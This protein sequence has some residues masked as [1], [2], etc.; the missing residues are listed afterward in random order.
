M[1]W[2]VPALALV[3]A[4]ALFALSDRLLSGGFE[5]GHEGGLERTA[6]REESRERVSADLTAPNA[7]QGSE[8]VAAEGTSSDLEVTAVQPD[9]EEELEPGGLRVRVIDAD[10]EPVPG[11]DVELV[12]R[13]P[14]G[15][16]QANWGT[17]TSSAPGGIAHIDLARLTQGMQRMQAY[18][19]EPQI[20]VRADIACSPTPSVELEGSPADG[21]QVD[22]VLPAMGTV[23]VRV[24]DHEGL[25]LEDEAEVYFWWQSKEEAERTSDGG[26]RRIGRHHRST[27]KG[28][29]R[30]EGIGLGISLSFT[31]WAPGLEGGS[32][33]GVDGP[34][35][36][37]EERVVEIRIGP[38]RPRVRLRVID[39]RGIPIA[40]TRIEAQFVQLL[41]GSASRGR[42][43]PRVQTEWVETDADG[44]AEFWS[45]A[46]AWDVDRALDVVVRTPN[47]S[48]QDD[49]AWRVGTVPLA[50][51]FAPSSTIDLGDVR[52]GPVPI[53]AEGVVVDEAG[54][55]LANVDLRFQE[56][57][58]DAWNERKD[59]SDGRV[60][61]DSNGHFLLR[62]TR[63]PERL[64]VYAYLKGFERLTGT[65]IAVG[66]R[67]VVLEL[68]PEVQIEPE[69]TGRI[70]IEV[71]MPKGTPFPRLGLYWRSEAGSHSTECPPGGVGPFE[72]K[73]LAPGTYAVWVKSRDGHLQFGRV[74]GVEVLADATTRDARLLPLDLENELRTVRLQLV[75]P[76]GK[77]LYKAQPEIILDALGKSFSVRTD[78]EG[79]AAFVVPKLTTGIGVSVDRE[80]RVD[81]ALALPADDSV[82]RVVIR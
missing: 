75:H 6:A 56:V 82:V 72:L 47:V 26:R 20:E 53:F 52:V 30:F 79:R 70:A 45:H 12:G 42:A 58:G 77:P 62:G 1:R 50:R 43:R 18:G 36:A 57:Y 71:A 13:I 32:L 64:S 11:V 5:G 48:A 69:P 8:R 27:S 2:L 65:E 66:D 29:A 44:L 59:L 21:S 24:L 76:S 7:S 74:E 28:L 35:D 46:R 17:G 60:R 15:Y 78:K 14:G 80:T 63:A 49:S 73:G 38:Q 9:S 3:A 25:P 10:G 31:A 37:G 67:T 54:D 34:Q 39:A 51:T 68:K 55:P 41:D 19:L 61:S 4:I 16:G 33:N 23:V 81:V 22:L 40:E